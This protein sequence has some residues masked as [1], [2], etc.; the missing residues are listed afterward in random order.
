MSL[1]F[2]PIPFL[3]EPKTEASLN[4]VQKFHQLHF[5]VQVTMDTEKFMYLYIP[6]L[7]AGLESSLPPKLMLRAVIIDIMAYIIS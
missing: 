5:T 6:E 1:P 2:H 3:Y 4:K 7:R